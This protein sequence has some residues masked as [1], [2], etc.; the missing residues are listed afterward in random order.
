MKEGSNG[1]VNSFIGTT[2][3]SKAVP[4]FTGEWDESIK[5]PSKTFA[6]GSCTA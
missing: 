3:G 6:L 2:E 1:L 5:A 4:E